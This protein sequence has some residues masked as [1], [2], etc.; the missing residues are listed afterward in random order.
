MIFAAYL[1]QYEKLLQQKYNVSTTICHKGER[2]RQRENG[3]AMFLRETL[4]AAYGVATG[5]VIPYMGASASPQC[6]IIIYDKLRMPIFGTSEPVQQVPLEGVYAIIETKSVLDSK[7]IADAIDKFRKIKNLP[8]CK[9]KKPL[10]KGSQRGPLFWLFG[11]R[12]SASTTACIDFMR[13]ISDSADVGVAALDKGLGIWVEMPQGSITAV[14][15]NTSD[16]K[17]DFHETL[18]YF[19]AGLLNELETID[20]GTRN[21]FEFLGDK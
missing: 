11:Y 7:A 1:A 19:F 14:W 5:E 17:D 15:M 12:L 6:D 4:P 10:R 16:E 2:G 8:R 21:Y 9:N 18:A 20:L 13:E 3:L